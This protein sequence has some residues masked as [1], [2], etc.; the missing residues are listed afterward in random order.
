MA[1]APG[2][3]NSRAIG[4]SGSVTITSDLGDSSSIVVSAIESFEGMSILGP[5]GS[6]VTI[7]TVGDVYYSGLRSIH[8]EEMPTWYTA[9]GANLT[10]YGSLGDKYWNGV[11]WTD[12]A[13]MNGVDTIYVNL[14]SS[15]G[16]KTENQIRQTIIHEVLHESKFLD[17]ESKAATSKIINLIHSGDLVGPATIDAE[18]LRS[19][20]EHAQIGMLT[21]QISRAAGYGTY[22]NRLF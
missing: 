16:F 4:S 12:Q 13:S 5:S 18:K 2:I 17:S 21:D 6:S 10:P 15:G 19:L 20:V 1:F 9:S 14:S 22:E 7:R 3:Q 11:K 8:V